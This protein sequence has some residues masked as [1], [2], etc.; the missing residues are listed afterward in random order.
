MAFF[1]FSPNDLREAGWAIVFHGEEDPAV[2]A[3]FQP[4]IEHRGS[5]IGNPELVKVFDYRDGESVQHWLARHKVSL[6]NVRPDR[7]PY[8]VLI[9]G[10]PERISFDFGLQLGLFYGVGRLHFDNPGGYRKYVESIIR[11]E[12][13][14][15]V[16]AGKEV[17]F[18]GT[19]HA[20]DPATKYS[21]EFLLKPLAD[22]TGERN[23]FARVAKVARVEYK[24][25]LI[26]PPEAT[27]SC[28]QS[29]FAPP[30]DRPSPP[31]LFVATHGVAWKKEDPR[32]RAEQ[33]ALVCQNYPGVGAG[34]LV[35][36]HYFAASDLGPEAHVFGMVCFLFASYSLG[37]PAQEILPRGEKDQVADQPFV[38]ALPQALLSHP[39]G[40]VLGV[41]GQTT[42]GW[43][44]P[45][46]QSTGGGG[47]EDK[48]T[49]LQPYENAITNILRGWPLG[50]ALREFSSRYAAL[51]A[52]LANL[53]EENLFGG[54][55]S[56]RELSKLVVERAS[57]GGFALLGDP[58]AQLNTRALR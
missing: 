13:S 19:R 23:L 37:T 44:S 22:E 27:K 25:K 26:S 10:S 53:Q 33:G 24:S 11:Y 41:I 14:T 48:W 35:P 42:R 6:G 21:S 5:R 47:A 12:T 7:V 31:L 15:T 17:L 38:T 39:N 40:G 57:M 49:H 55:V 43:L 54:T 20:N 1:D 51:S 45:Q 56:E 50:H 58:A 36:D 3:A 30:P 8:Y 28:L 18:F 4:L 9:V 16:L 34:P 32:Q 46:Q 29:I 52:Q 2:V